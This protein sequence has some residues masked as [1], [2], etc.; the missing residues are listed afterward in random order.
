LARPNPVHPWRIV[1]PLDGATRPGQ[2]ARRPGG[3]RRRGP[4][5]L[6]LEVD[7]QSFGNYPL[8][9]ETLYAR[10]LNWPAPDEEGEHTFTVTTVNLN[11][12]ESEPQSITVT[13]QDTEA[14]NAALRAEVE[15]NVIELRGLPPLSPITPVV[16]TRDELRDRLAKPQRDDARKGPRRC[17]LIG[18]GTRLRPYAAQLQRRATVSWAL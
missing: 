14:R 9:G 18:P 13:V 6:T 12:V 17:A 5:H 1:T 4:D 15:A 8:D 10:T 16:L 11:G 3:R 2:P 7:G